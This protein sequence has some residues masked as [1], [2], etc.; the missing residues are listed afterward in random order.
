MVEKREV[1]PGDVF[2]DFYGRAVDSIREL[3][4]KPRF[5]PF[6]RFFG[7]VPREV[8]MKAQRDADLLLLLESPD[9]AS[10]GV[11]TGKVFEYITAGRPI[12]CVGSH[13]EY[14]IGTLLRCTGTGKVLGRADSEE[15]ASIIKERLQGAGR[16][17]WFAPNIEEIRRYSR[18][19][20]AL[21]LLD[22]IVKRRK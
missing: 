11:L 2:L 7:H 5:K 20:Q 22:E 18:R 21:A 19:T 17:A 8:A 16:P 1:K 14:E 3:Q 6:L 9:A 4:G 13:P 10:R 15:M 12:I